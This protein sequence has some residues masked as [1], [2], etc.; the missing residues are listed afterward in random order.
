MSEFL[1]DDP[2]ITE[3]FEAFAE[4]NCKVFED[5]DENKL[6]RHTET[7]THTVAHIADAL[8][9][10]FEPITRLTVSDA[11]RCYSSGVH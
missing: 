8:R 3:D 5:T 6:V 4:E 10:I 1:L 9:S 7:L 11:V 2:S